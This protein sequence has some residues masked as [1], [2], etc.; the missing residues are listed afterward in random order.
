MLDVNHT[1]G[2]TR[3]HFYEPVW[4][5]IMHEARRTGSLLLWIIAYAGAAAH[6][7]N[8]TPWTEGLR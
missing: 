3:T 5:T 7:K 2:V 8:K 1:T 4:A 6:D